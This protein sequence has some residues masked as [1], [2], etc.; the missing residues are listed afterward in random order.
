MPENINAPEAISGSLKR[1]TFLRKHA[2]RPLR[3]YMYME[4]GLAPSHSFS[5]LLIPPPPPLQKLSKC[6]PVVCVLMPI[7]HTQ[8]NGITMFL[9]ELCIASCVIIPLMISHQA[10]YSTAN[11]HLAVFRAHKRGRAHNWV[12]LIRFLSS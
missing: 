8:L 12:L 6:R 9:F 10:E 5:Y 1:K 7:C 11:D 2:L 3:A 4:N